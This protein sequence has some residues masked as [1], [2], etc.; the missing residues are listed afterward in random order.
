MANKFIDKFIETLPH[1]TNLEGSY[2]WLKDNRLLK[3]YKLCAKCNLPLFCT[4]S[5]WNQKFLSYYC[6]NRNCNKYLKEILDVD[7][8]FFNF[9]QKKIEMIPRMIHLIH[10]WLVN[11]SVSEAS[12]RLNLS[13]YNA[14]NSYKKCRLFCTIF[15]Q[16]Y[17]IVLGD[18]GSVV[19]VKLLEFPFKMATQTIKILMMVDT[20][21][22]PLIVYM[23][24]IKYEDLNVATILSA[25]KN[26]VKK[27]TTV[28]VVQNHS[29]VAC[30]EL[31]KLQQVE[32]NKFMFINCNEN[33]EKVINS[34]C[35]RHLEIIKKLMNKNVVE[36]ENYLNEC[37]W[38][39]RYEND[40]IKNFIY[41]LRCIYT[42]E[43][44]P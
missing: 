31:A 17:P 9:T 15:F 24:I 5:T 6:T 39:E 2:Q 3:E 36:P 27:N 19:V 22:D 43:N 32:G 18:E 13:L 11:V 37:M 16:K 10:Y 33:Q 29:V 4:S 28:A 35:D 12:T 26:V 8:T 40:A 21:E 25:I 20:K 38:R 41:H 30:D 14:M 34:Y 1:Y 23:K 7:E 42:P 44:L